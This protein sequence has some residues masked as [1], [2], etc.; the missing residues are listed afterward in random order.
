M[1]IVRNRSIEVV[2]DILVCSLL[3]LCHLITLGRAPVWNWSM[4]AGVIAKLAQLSIL[5]GRLIIEFSRWDLRELTK[6]TARMVWLLLILEVA[7]I[8]SRRWSQWLIV[9]I[10]WR[11]L[12]L[13]HLTSE[14]LQAIRRWVRH[15]QPLSKLKYLKLLIL[16]LI[17]MRLD[18]LILSMHCHVG[19]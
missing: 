14:I 17:L 4:A 7:L 5:D 1:L 6:I 10:L 19:N 8:L 11:E 12:L 9:D 2:G 16:R 13:P 18:Q 3:L 15:V